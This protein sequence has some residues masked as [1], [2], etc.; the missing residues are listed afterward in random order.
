MK[1]KDKL[2]ELD[3]CKEAVD[4]VGVMTG[5]SAQKLGK[6]GWIVLMLTK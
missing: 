1:A 6:H 4:W 3:A 5:K 2:I